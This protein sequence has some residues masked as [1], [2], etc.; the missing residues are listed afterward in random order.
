MYAWPLAL[1]VLAV[2]AGRYNLRDLKARASGAG[3]LTGALLVLL[4]I[5]TLILAGVI[6]GSVLVYRLGHTLLEL[7]VVVGYLVYV[8]KPE[9]FVRARENVKV[10]SQRALVLAADEELEIRHRLEK[11]QTENLVFQESGLDLA[12]LARRIG[13]PAYRLS[14][15]FNGTLEVSFSS[16]LNKVRITWASERMLA[17]PDRAVLDIALEAGYG[18]KSVFNS[19][20]HKLT[21]QSPTSYRLKHRN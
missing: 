3:A 16:W 8:A 13:V 17:E 19:Q 10:A 12:D 21:G 9:P 18:S 1:V 4:A 2:T 15:Y 14:L 7:A 6:A 20:F 5:L 11:L